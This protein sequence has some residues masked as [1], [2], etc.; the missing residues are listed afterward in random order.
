MILLASSQRA[1]IL[2]LRG[3]K[4]IAEFDRNEVLQRMN[5]RAK[6]LEKTLKERNLP[7]RMI[8]RL[9][10]KRT[11]KLSVLLLKQGK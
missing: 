6:E 7:Q 11:A 5:E 2:N 4:M 10:M 8:N 1:G 9:I 3:G